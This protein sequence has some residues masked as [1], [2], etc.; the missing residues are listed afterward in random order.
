MEVCPTYLLVDI[1]QQIRPPRE[2]SGFVVHHLPILV[3]LWQYFLLW[4]LIN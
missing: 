3:E 2:V 1:L 4:F